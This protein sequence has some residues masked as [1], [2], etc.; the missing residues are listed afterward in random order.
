VSIVTVQEVGRRWVDLSV[1]DTGIGIAREQLE[2]L[3]EDFS[4]A[5]A[6]TQRKFGGTGLGLAISRRICQAMGGDLN[7]VSELGKGSTFTARLPEDPSPGDAA[8]EPQPESRVAEMKL[9]APRPGVV[10]IVDDNRESRELLVDLLA[11]LGFATATASDGMEG[12]RRARELHPAAMA[13]DVA[14]PGLNGWSVLAA[15]KEDPELCVVPVIIIAALGSELKKGY[16]LGAAAC[17]TKPV[18]HKLLAEA[19]NHLTGRDGARPAA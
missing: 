16:S 13:L 8:P 17:L 2:K 4:Q 18:D 15:M 10:L 7:V 19:L 14:M 9:P 1:T 12:L 3:F 11:R 5:D 6:A